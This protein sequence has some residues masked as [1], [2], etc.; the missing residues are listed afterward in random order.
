M[1]IVPTVTM[2]SVE[3]IELYLARI[4]HAYKNDFLPIAEFIETYGASP[5]NEIEEQRKRLK[6]V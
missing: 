1:A 5:P 6:G 2:D 3:D 4:E